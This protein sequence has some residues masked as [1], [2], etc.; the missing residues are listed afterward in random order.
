MS[1]L[2]LGR[3]RLIMLPESRQGSTHNRTGSG[4]TYPRRGYGLAIHADQN[5]LDWGRALA[6]VVPGYR[7]VR[8]STQTRWYMSLFSCAAG[9]DN[10]QTTAPA[11]APAMAS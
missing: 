6:G 4:G 9:G 1:D 7:L 10:S 11:A 3:I 5:E 2:S 8:S